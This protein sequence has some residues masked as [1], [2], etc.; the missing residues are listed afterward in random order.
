LLS[1]VTWPPA[2]WLAFVSERDA[3]HRRQ[4]WP[5]DGTSAAG[6]RPVPRT[7]WMPG[8]RGRSG[9]RRAPCSVRSSPDWH[10]HYHRKA[11]PR[12]ERFIQRCL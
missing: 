12:G 10:K 3:A 8:P 7:A 5:L 4:Y 11:K 6:R 2:A 1:L 9:K